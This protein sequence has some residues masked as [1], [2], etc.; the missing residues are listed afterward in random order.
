M[1]MCKLK[2]ISIL[3]LSQNKLSG[4]IPHCLNNI[5]FT[6]KDQMDGTLLG[7]F[8]VPWTTRGPVFYF[9]YT[10]GDLV[11]DEYERNSTWYEQQ[12]V[13]FMSK[14]RY[15]S[16]E[17][18]IL[19]FMSGLD[20]SNNQLTGEIPL[21]IGYLNNIHTLN[22]SDNYLTGP[23]P[24]TFSG[25][26]QI[27]SLDL[28]H[29]DLTGHIPSQLTQLYSLSVFSVAHNN[30]SGKTPD[31]K[32]QFST[33]DPSCYEGNP[34]LCGPPLQQKCSS[35]DNPSGRNIQPHHSE[36]VGF[37]DAFLWT[38]SGAFAVFFL[39]VITCLYFNSYFYSYK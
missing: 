18:K 21:E 11:H 4:G 20:L 32:N 38:F 39:G 3:D 34:F 25:L 15:E 30:L 23:I 24:E 27:E 37:R 6:K 5:T 35:I 13:N 14:N 28:S 19:D 10:S 1:E 36:E 9:N 16:Y 22:M 26:M 8:V 2:N 29:N 31:M 12:E 7:K 33:F 17:G